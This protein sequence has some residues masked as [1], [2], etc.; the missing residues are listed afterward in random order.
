M[1]FT[2]PRRGFAAVLATLVSALL[3]MPSG[4]AFADEQPTPHPTE[5]E[6]QT[7]LLSDP[8][9]EEDPAL[10][11]AVETLEPA[12]TQTPT[13]EPAQ[14]PTPQVVEQSKSKDVVTDVETE[15][16]EPRASRNVQADAG[17]PLTCEPGYV[18]SIG[19]NG[20]IYE[21]NP[22]GNPR[23]IANLGFQ[24]A[25][26]EFNGIGIG[27]GG[28]PVY[29][30]Y[31]HSTTRAILYR[32]NGPGSVPEVI[33]TS[34][35]G[36]NGSLVAGAADL[37]TGGYY[38]GG[39]E[40]KYLYRYWKGG[41]FGRWVNVY[42][43][44]FRIWKYDNESVREVGY[45]NTG[46]NIEDI[47]AANGDIAFNARGDLFFLV[48]GGDKAAIGTITADEL[49]T[50]HGGEL[51]SSSTAL[52]Q[53]S[54]GTNGGNANGIAF[55][56]DGSVY[57][58]T[59]DYLYKYNPTTWQ[60]I[61]QPRKVLRD[62]TDLAGCS[63]PSSIEITKNVV[64]RKDATDQFTLWMKRGDAEVARATTEGSRSGQQN[65]QIGPVVALRGETYSISE[66]IA[67]GS[68]SDL[69]TDYETNWVCTDEEGWKDSGEGTEFEITVTRLGQS[70]S[71]EFTNTPVPDTQ[72]TLR[73]KFETSY[74]ASEKTED[75]TLTAT[76][77]GGKTSEFDHGQT[78]QVE[79][80]E[81][82]IAELFGDDKIAPDAAGYELADITCTTD[83]RSNPVANGR[84]TLPNRTATECVLTNKDKQGSVVWAK[85]SQNETPLADSEW[86]LSGPEGFGERAVVD[87]GEH[88][89]DK[90]DGYF[91][92]QGLHWGEYTLKETKAPAGFELM[93]ETA[94]VEITG[95][96]R[97]YTFDEPFINEPLQP[98]TLP[99]T[100][101]FSS[102]WSLIGGAGLALAVLTG[103]AGT[104]RRRKSN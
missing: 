22:S 61:G 70:I 103:L 10:D 28:G 54:G 29:A 20:E 67:E 31:R 66:V 49:R 102:K 3:I 63:S 58:G 60:Q 77:N 48:S 16:P 75:W 19:R 91:E 15:E 46:I 69:P 33:Q 65:K 38:F 88:D 2:S 1:T 55:D 45:V 83:G 44:Q 72:L 41:L 32:W 14:S 6:T 11:D 47:S 7:T 53:L 59:T 26:N 104:L 9:V 87:N 43:Y 98:G 97:K 100:G 76:L 62:S 85:T 79:A 74:G 35:H 51:Q 52:K 36:L 39:Y 81:Y 95:T 13:A 24:G 42:E 27:P 78:K 84:V 73:K 17:Q 50:A 21:I 89:A 93:S 92:V 80:G 30:Y 99:L 82:A 56:P 18:Y 64:D 40:Q 68:A 96:Q 71:C 5:I 4:I 94:A 25:N 8:A 86:L 101:I 57:L 34:N 12:E 90:R 37:K 23:E